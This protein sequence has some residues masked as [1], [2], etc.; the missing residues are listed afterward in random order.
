M[1]TRKLLNTATATFLLCVFTSVS[2]PVFAQANDIP[3]LANGKPDFNGMWD[4]PRV[5]NISQDVSGRCGSGSDGC[6]SIS[7]GPIEFTPEGLA[8]H[9]GPKIDWPARCMPWGYTRA[10]HTSYPVMYM[11]TPDVFAVLF[12]SNN[13]FHI[14]PTDGR[15]LADDLEPTWMGKSVGR[16]EGDT[17]VIE[18]RGFNGK[19]WLDNVGEHP[20]SD[21]MQIV[22]R[23]RH[24]D[25][26][27]LEYKITI[28][29]PKYYAKPI[30]NDRVFVRMDEDAEIY[31]YW[32]MENNKDLMEGLLSETLLTG[33]H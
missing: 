4:R 5:S 6:S 12:E 26:D 19:S 29:D 13:I 28:E 20:T 25:A 33:E 32:C 3:R 22:E 31:E 21:Q 27:T 1:N 24:I 23:I 15:E 11:H 8:V 30:V 7:N 18:S 17:L 10:Y 2:A 9:T 16:F 14:V